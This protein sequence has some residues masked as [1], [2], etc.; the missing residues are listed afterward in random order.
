MMKVLV[1]D[2]ESLARD[3]LKGLL[4]RLGDV[5]IVGEAADGKEAVERTS[6]L[7]PDI[8][9]LDIRMPSMDGLEAARHIAALPDPPAV[10]FT[11]AFGE[12]ALEAFEAAACDYL[13]K[14]I[15]AERLHRALAGALRLTRPQAS[16]LQQEAQ[17]RRE[18][19]AVHTRTGL[20]LVP[21]AAI[22][23]FKADH[24]YTLVRT[25][26]EEFLIEESLKSLE[27]E[28]GDLFLRVHRN[29]LVN[30]SH[31]HSLHNLQS[32]AQ[33]ISLN[34]IEERLQ[35]S[36][37]HIARIRKYLDHRCGVMRA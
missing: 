9:L 16:R 6:Q 15:K 11:T 31:L 7:S 8:V 24:K 13:V 1:V 37:G 19:I 10:I 21:V 14:P 17:K 33:E 32:G 34:G 12:Y 27:E 20:R 30:R 4:A 2:D 3:R 23:Y 25:A 29:A 5:E 36:R 26:E 28:F 18:H 35:V 22:R